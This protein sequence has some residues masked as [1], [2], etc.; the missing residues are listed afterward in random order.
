MWTQNRRRGLHC[1]YWIQDFKP[2]PPP[3]PAPCCSSSLCVR[4]RFRMWRLYCP[5]LFLNLLYFGVSKGLWFVIVACI[6]CLQLQSNLDSSNTDGSF[7][8]ANS[9]SFLSPYEIL[10][11]ALKNKI[12]G[13]IFLF[14]HKIVCC[15]YSLESPQ[16]FLWVHSTYNYC[17]ENR[18]DF[19]K[20]SLFASWPGAMI[21]FIGSN[22]PWLEHF[23]MVPKVFEPL[24]FDCIC[25]YIIWQ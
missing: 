16:L 13:G 4:R 6:C 9:N 14:Y 23:S 11:I 3:H 8:M 12:F 7:T 2:L 24:K 22:Y 10:P 20:L 1:L 19:P 21:N 17:V 15:M 18:K 25:F 5:Y